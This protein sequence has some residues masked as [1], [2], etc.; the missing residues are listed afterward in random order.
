MQ[1][2]STHS[3]LLTVVY[4]LG[5]A[6]QSEH[7]SEGWLLSD[8][9]LSP[10]DHLDLTA[11]H[12]DQHAFGLSH[13]TQLAVITSG[14]WM[15]MLMSGGDVIPGQNSGITAADQLQ[16][17]QPCSGSTSRAASPCQ[18]ED[19][20]QAV[21][22]EDDEAIIPPLLSQCNGLDDPFPASPLAN[23]MQST[24]RASQG[25]QPAPLL[26]ISQ[27]RPTAGEH[28][29]GDSLD[30]AV[31]LAGL[32]AGAFCD[33]ITDSAEGLL[34][35]A[36]GDQHPISL[37][38]SAANSLSDLSAADQGNAG[39]GDSALLKNSQANAAELAQPDQQNANHDQSSGCKRKARKAA[40]RHQPG[41][42]ASKPGQESPGLDALLAD[43]IETGKLPFEVPSMPDSGLSQ[44]DAG[45]SALC[46][47]WKHAMSI[48]ALLEP[49]SHQS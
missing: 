45:K 3:Q 18:V 8:S 15:Q 46:H 2:S 4:C 36:I 17:H 48:Q 43:F 44:Q 7:W 37:H 38:P 23:S 28:W 47:C 35:P 49:W 20:L 13:G 40:Y 22:A 24:D 16:P 31:R 21:L 41:R 5:T 9:A 32:P 27:G 29:A 11:C 19:W 12:E 42:A 6:S 14:E 33:D 39:N 26:G 1:L 10:T 30:C 25:N 34:K